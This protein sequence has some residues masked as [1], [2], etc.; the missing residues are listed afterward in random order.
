MSRT[1]EKYIDEVLTGKIS[2]SAT[3]RLTFE[4]HARDLRVAP[5][6]GWYFDKRAV[7]K[8]LD[9]CTL[10]RHS[11]DKKTWVP[12]HP[13]PWQ[14]AVMYIVFGWHKKDGTRRFNYAYVE[15]PKK[16]GKTTWSAVIANYLLFFDGENEAEIYT[17]ATIEKQAKIC[18]NMAKKMIEKSPALAKRARVLTRNVTYAETSSKLEP[19]GRDSSSME[20]INPHGGV[21]DELHVWNT[22]E[23]FENMQSA[24]VNRRQP[25]FW[26]ITTSGRD[27]TLPCFSYRQL[28]IDILKGIKTQPDTFGVIYTLDET[29]DWKDPAAWKKANPNWNVSVLPDRFQSEFQGALND[30]AKEVSFKTKN[31]NLW[32][33]APTV[34]IPD[35][36]WLLCSFGTD[37]ETLKGKRCYWGLD[38]ASHVDINALALY[39]PDIDGHPVFRMYYWIPEAKVTEKKD[40]V[41]YASW[42]NA[43][44]I[45]TTPGDVIDIDTMVA[46]ILKIV[47]E[48]DCQGMAF[49]PAKAYHGVI[50]GLMRDGF[51]GDKMDEFSQGIMTMSAPTKEFERLVMSGQPDHLNDPVLRWMLGNVQ[52]YHDINDNIKADKKRSRDKIDGIVALVMAIGECMTINDSKDT[53]AIYTHG[54]SLRLV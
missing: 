46:D 22:F 35:E 52:I 9:F 2:V 44:Y 25:L 31:L 1:A 41:D 18:F 10:L 5:E 24:S 48:Y 32:V 43:G 11:P 15:I 23:V 38:L 26:I 7:K 4:R 53:K 17:A 30:S 36:K 45:K 28:V 6:N 39:F 16:N 19:L 54:H 14:E 47:K 51:P 42:V 50:Q 27:K 21:L 29:D 49:D 37:P 40:K 13:E 20:G 33:D 3:T 12:F 34:W 8:V